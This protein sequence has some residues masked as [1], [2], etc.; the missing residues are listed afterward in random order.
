[1]PSNS[2]ISIKML[3]Q[4]NSEDSVKE[5]HINQLAYCPTCIK[6]LS[7][8]LSPLS[9]ISHLTPTFLFLPSAL[10]KYFVGFLNQIH[11]LLFLHLC[12]CYSFISEL[13]LALC[14]FFA[15]QYPIHLA[16]PNFCLHGRFPDSL[17]Q[18]EVT[19]I[20]AL[21]PMFLKCFFFG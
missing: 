10:L 13:L 1:M 12:T 4:A 11:S 14:R 17:K 9:L 21:I 15:C 19:L 16:D 2:V 6:C 8:L 7:F 5:M 3:T 20:C 18:F